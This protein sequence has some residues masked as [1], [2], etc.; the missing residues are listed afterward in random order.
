MSRIFC[1]L[2]PKQGRNSYPGHFWDTRFH[3][4]GPGIC[5]AD[6][7]KPYGKTPLEC[8]PA[9]FSRSLAFI[10]LALERKTEIEPPISF[11]YVSIVCEIFPISRSPMRRS[12]FALQYLSIL[13]YKDNVNFLNL[14][15][16]HD[17]DEK[18][19]NLL[20]NGSILTAILWLIKYWHFKFLY[21][22]NFP[23]LYSK[24]R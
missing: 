3:W 9:G 14:Q 7:W 12:W 22:G 16:L 5:S 10:V 1:Q 18:L 17:M 8:I 13:Q 2:S 19:P 21:I 11:R 15:V 6:R 24:Y 4:K 23:C 20:F